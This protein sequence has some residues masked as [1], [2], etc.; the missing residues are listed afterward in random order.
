MPFESQFVLSMEITRLVPLAGAINKAMDMVIKFARDLRVSPARPNKK[1][2]RSD[3]WQD[4]GSDIM[5]EADLAE[6]FGRCRIAQHMES[7]FRAVVAVSGGITDLCDGLELVTTP[8]PTVLRSLI[9]EQGHYLSTVIQCSL[10]A[11]V[12]GPGRIGSFC[13]HQPT[14]A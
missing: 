8:G 14:P 2:D 12:S 11:S 5:V 3:G 13:R 7:S 6:F 4:T 9:S 1:S 10:L